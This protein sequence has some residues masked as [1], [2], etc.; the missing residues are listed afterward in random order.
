MCTRDLSLFQ[1]AVSSLGIGAS[2]NI[3]MR[4][5]AIKNLIKADKK[6]VTQLNEGFEK[7]KRY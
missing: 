5:A 2:V 3:R 7:A 4:W 1:R 6:I